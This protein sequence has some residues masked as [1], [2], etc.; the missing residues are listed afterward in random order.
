M[1]GGLWSTA[2]WSDFS[3]S[4]RLFSAEVSLGGFTSSY[5]SNCQ[6]RIFSRFRNHKIVSLKTKQTLISRDASSSFRKAIRIYCFL[7]NKTEK[8]RPHVFELNLLCLP[9]LWALLFHTITSS[10]LMPRLQQPT[11]HLIIAVW[12]ISKRIMRMKCDKNYFHVT[13]EHLTSAW[14]VQQSTKGQIS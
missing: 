5:K 8:L 2:D 13:V 4:A 10:R 12:D 9:G 14:P 11:F 6:N 1:K 3:T 7:Y